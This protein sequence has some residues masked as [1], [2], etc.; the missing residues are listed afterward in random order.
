MV[1]KSELLT[2]GPTT[3]GIIRSP[4]FSDTLSWEDRQRLRAIVEKTHRHYFRD[5]LSN[6][7]KD[8][9]IDQLGPKVRMKMLERAIKAGKVG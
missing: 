3:A 2:T 4:G 1:K 8:K 9:L 5:P 7:E 6:V